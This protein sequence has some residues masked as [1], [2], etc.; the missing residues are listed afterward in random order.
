VATLD[1]IKIEVNKYYENILQRIAGEDEVNSW[2][3]PV[4]AGALTIE[5]VRQAFINS[6]EAQNV[7]GVV[8]VYQ[9][10]FGRV[11][12]QE[13]LK[14][15]VNSGL[16]MDQIAE[17]FVNSEEFTNRYGSNNV[18]EAFVTSLYFQVLGRAPDAEGLANWTNSGLS[19]AQILAGFS[20]SQEFKNTTSVAVS[21]FLD[22]AGK[23]TEDYSG[24]LNEY[25]PGG[26][27]PGTSGQTF[28]LTAGVVGD[29]FVGDA[30]DD[31]FVA[32]SVAR[33]GN[34]DV[35]DGG[36]GN[37]TLTAKLSTDVTPNLSSIET[38]NIQAIGADA[39]LN[40]S[41]ISGAKQLNVT[42]GGTLTYTDAEA[43][44]AVSLAGDATSLTIDPAGTDTN[45]QAV[46]IDLLSGKLG[47]ITEGAGSD[48]DQIT[49]VASGAE[50]VTLAA[51]AGG[52]FVDIGEK[53]I[54]TG[55]KELTL[56]V[57][58]AQIGESTATATEVVID[59][60]GHTGML[61][62]DV[63]TFSL[64]NGKLD[65]S[66]VSAF[67]VVRAGLKGSNEISGLTSGMTVRVDEAASDSLKVSVDGTSTTDSI[68]VELNHATDGSSVAVGTLTT[69]GIETVHVTSSGKDTETSKVSNSVSSIF[70]DTDKSSLVIDGDKLL[71]VSSVDKQFTSIDASAAGAGVDLTVEAGGNVTFTGSAAADRLELA[72]LGDLNKLDVLKGGDGVDTL[73]IAGAIGASDFTDE[74]RAAVSGFEVLELKDAQ[75]AASV[76]SIDLTKFSSVN[77]LVLNGL[78]GGSLAV[79]AQDSFTLEMGAS[80]VT[81]ANL[82]VQIA[83]AATGGTNNTVNLHLTNAADAGYT[84]NG[85]Q[86]KNV[87]NLS[88][89]LLGDESGI[90]TVSGPDVID[91]TNVAG[92]QLRTI[93]I[94]SANTGTEV[95]GTIKASDSLTITDVQSVLIEK[96][97]ASAATGDINIDGLSDN[98]IATGATLVGGSGSDTITGGNGA[99]QITGG[100][101]NDTLDGG[102]ADDII[103]GEE[104]DDTLIGGLGD[105]VIDGGEGNDT[106]RGGAGNDELTGWNGK[107]TFVFEATAA[108]NGVDTITEFTAGDATNADVLDFGSLFLGTTAATAANMALTASSA[109]IALAVDNVYVMKLNAAITDKDYSAANFSD[110][111]G[112][113]TGQFSTSFSEGGKAVILVQGS[114]VTKAYMVSEVVDTGT[115]NT[116]IAGSEISLVGV[117][118]T[119]GTYH[120]SNFA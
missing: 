4:N 100:K 95:D 117:I 33:L 98:L 74:Q 54:I 89:S 116:S 118:N 13:G 109:N 14:N 80:S 59:G 108:G 41:L 37:D 115:N 21:T 119:V 39:G 71:T 36:E 64:N 63:G 32:A 103:S 16:S 107:D 65:L 38:L 20:E 25:K 47:A 7:A 61:G 15:W 66:K 3:A 92:A 81:A 99:D 40:G 94:A 73:S 6:S 93:T 82:D 105:D 30:G 104:G 110:L 10:A 27:E 35:L 31:Q 28:T 113:G 26:E 24:S 83:G 11:P 112:T 52:N 76:R 58:A 17:G 56:S 120:E 77:T 53:I 12:D 79:K 88:I 97:D 49:L 68:T 34:D 114:D 19:A 44:L 62:L 8:R 101:G 86:I 51:A 9:A 90:A 50:S 60:K 1:E 2:A 111:F 18:T 46:T 42:G 48:Y 84:N 45:T 57:A 23:G 106:I 96:I 67:D 69:T 85:L 75:T 55:D 102:E 70:T 72:T 91:L 87:E 78:T 29:D 22:N 43:G 5:Q